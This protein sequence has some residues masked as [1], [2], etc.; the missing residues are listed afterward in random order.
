MQGKAIRIAIRACAVTGMLM[1]TAGYA[2]AASA[3]TNRESAQ[4]AVLNGQHVAVPA[5][6]APGEPNNSIFPMPVGAEGGILLTGVVGAAF[7]GNQWRR[8]RKLSKL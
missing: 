8:K 4:V 6:Q 5:N 1:L 2:S 7:I 3:Q